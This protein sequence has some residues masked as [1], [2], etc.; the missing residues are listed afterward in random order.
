MIKKFLI[1]LVTTF[2]QIGVVL[3]VLIK[4]KNLNHY[5][6]QHLLQKYFEL[7]N[8]LYMEFHY[9]RKNLL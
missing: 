6:Y 2:A 3:A 7:Q 5:V 4:T 1:N 9:Q 8:Q